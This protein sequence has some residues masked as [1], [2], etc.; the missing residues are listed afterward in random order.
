M[1]NKLINFGQKALNLPKTVAIVQVGNNRE[2]SRQIKKE[3]KWLEFFGSKVEWYYFDSDIKAA[4]LD[5]EIYENLTPYVDKVFLRPITALEDR[6]I[7]EY[8]EEIERMRAN[9]I[10]RSSS[11]TISV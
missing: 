1:I 3:K 9:G 10:N 11:G 2:I 5:F 6:Y 4:D 7:E 8:K